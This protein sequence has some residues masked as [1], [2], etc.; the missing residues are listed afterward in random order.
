M[1]LGSI[2]IFVCVTMLDISVLIF[3]FRRL[4]QKTSWQFSLKSLMIFVTLF[5]VWLSQFSISHYEL[6]SDEGLIWKDLFIVGFV[7]IV[8]VLY[9][10][11]TKSILALIAH[12][13]PII[14][15]ILLSTGNAITFANFFN[16]LIGGCFIGSSVSFPVW[17]LT[18]SEIIDRP[19][20]IPSD[21][22]SGSDS[23]ENNHD[24]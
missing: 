9:Y 18:V 19:K 11:W 21:V 16:A 17:A 13:F 24:C 12:C 6:R 23:N 7:W 2:L 22:A 10:S 8:L 1:S 15:C 4:R 3:L 20:K 14:A 5:A